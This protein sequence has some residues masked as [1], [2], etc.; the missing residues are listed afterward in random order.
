LFLCS[1]LISTLLIMLKPASCQYQFYLEMRARFFAAPAPPQLAF[2]RAFERREWP[3][4]MF[5]LC[6]ARFDNCA[7]NLFG[8][9]VTRRSLVQRHAPV[10]VDDNA[11][12]SVLVINR[13]LR[14][15]PHRFA[16]RQ[17]PARAVIDRITTARRTREWAQDVT[18]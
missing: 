14:E 13:A 1:S 9:F 7:Y 12:R 3:Q 8:R 15:R 11:S 5:D 4:A 10:R 18:P 16:A 17:T 6:E 2:I